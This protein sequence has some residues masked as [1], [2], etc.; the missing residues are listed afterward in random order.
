MHA[1]AFILQGWTLF[2]IK[3]VTNFF[4]IALKIFR[5]ASLFN[6]IKIFVI[7]ATL[8]PSCFVFICERQDYPQDRIKN[9]SDVEGLGSHFHRN[10]KEIFCIN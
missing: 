1:A 10:G 3:K 4:Q 9:F 7:S 6:I 2:L 8:S 5:K